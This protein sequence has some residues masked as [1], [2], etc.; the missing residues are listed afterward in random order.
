MNPKQLAA[1][2]ALPLV[3]SGMIVGLGTG[4]TADFFLKALGD[5]LA[6]GTL[7]NIRGVPTSV[8]SDRR[9]R[10]LGIPL[11]T[12]A[13][14]PHP[15]ITVDGADEVDPQLNLIKGLGGALLRE[16]IVAQASKTLVIIADQSKTVST[17]GTRSPLPVEVAPFCYE[18]H[19]LFLKSLGADP[20][21]R[22]N[23]DGNPY[24]T[25]NG[26]YIFD[27]RFKAIADPAGLQRTLK[28]R[29]GIVESGLFIGLATTAFIATDSG[30]KTMKKN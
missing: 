3:K 11:T 26:N 2:A 9:A 20:V 4:S 15:D 30:V 25:D 16:K 18:V 12:L 19:A 5:A 8:Q 22:R 14:S 21:L 6:A 1:E 7:K 10:E 28:D 29:A 23:A 17:L 13:E 24:V 27:S